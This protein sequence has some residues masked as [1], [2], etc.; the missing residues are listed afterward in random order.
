MKGNE[1]KWRQII[2]NDEGERDKRELR[3]KIPGK[4]KQEKESKRKIETKERKTQR[5]REDKNPAYLFSSP[6]LFLLTLKVFSAVILAIHKN[7]IYINYFCMF[8]VVNYFY[9]S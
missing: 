8:F 2:Q 7:Y 3:R 9:V 1:S 6:S 5:K 4:K